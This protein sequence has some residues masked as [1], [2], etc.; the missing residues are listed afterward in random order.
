MTARER[1]WPLRKVSPAQQYI[2]SANT[3][4]AAIPLSQVSLLHPLTNLN[5]ISSLLSYLYHLR[6]KIIKESFIKVDAKFAFFCLWVS[7]D[8]GF[9]C[10]ESV[11]V[12]SLVLM[13]LDIVLTS[14]RLQQHFEFVKFD[15]S[16]TVLVNRHNQLL[17]ID[18]HLEFFLDC[19]NQLLSIN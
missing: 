16:R 2:I 10:Q 17:D 15:L 11:S 7:F 19:A 9:E 8:I 14:S 12:D 1:E 18:C 4:D 13:E 6:A 5:S 3:L